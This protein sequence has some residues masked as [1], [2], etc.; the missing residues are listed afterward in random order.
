SPHA[1]VRTSRFDVWF[2]EREIR[3]CPVTLVLDSP[4]RL[5]FRAVIACARVEAVAVKEMVFDAAFAVRRCMTSLSKEDAMSTDQV[6]RRIGDLRDRDEEVRSGAAY[7]RGEIGPAAKEA[8]PALIESLKDQ[9]KGVRCWA[10]WALG[11]IGPAKNVV[12]A[13]I[14]RFKDQEND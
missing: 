10:A 13:L 1:G 3:F 9:D 5:C 2:S 4:T 8:V 6:A 11:E 12:P 7:V 14:E